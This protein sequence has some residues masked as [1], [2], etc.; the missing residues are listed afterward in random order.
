MSSYGILSCGCYKYPVIDGV[1]VIRKEPINVLAHVSSAIQ[2][3]GPTPDFLASLILQQKGQE[4]LLRMITFPWCSSI[5]KKFRLLRRI[6]H[7]NPFRAIGLAL[8][9]SSLRSWIRN[10]PGS[11]TAEDWFALFYK[12]TVIRGDLFSYFFY[13]FVQ[14][15]HLAALSLMTTFPKCSKPLL[16]LACGFGHLSHYLT[17]CEKSHQVVGFDRNFFQLWVGKHWIA[18]KAHFLCGDADLAMPFKDGSFD[19]VFCSDAFHYF[20]NKTECVNEMHRCAPDGTIILTRVGNQLV[21]PNEGKELSPDGYL[22]LFSKSECRALGETELMNAYLKGMAPNLSIQK[23]PESLNNEKWLSIIESS[24]RSMFKDHGKFESWPHGV[25]HLGVN[26][27]YLQSVSGNNGQVH[28][29]FHFPSSWFEFENQSMQA[30]HPSSIFI[31]KDVYQ[32][33]RSNQRT[34][35]VEDLISK[36]VIIGMPKNYAVSQ[37]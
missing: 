12:R 21:Q 3:A 35:G 22:D 30:Y 18:P 15:R 28:L 25:G 24:D 5:F 9:K 31:E 1:P 17:E 11:L 19:G 33:I 16:D 10:P 27:I 2:V 14:P 34:E 8:R 32:E 23:E 37:Q 6:I 29:D 7:R 36:F 13:R 20:Q 26:P 4:A